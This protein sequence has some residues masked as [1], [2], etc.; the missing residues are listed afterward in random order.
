MIAP[1]MIEEQLEKLSDPS[2]NVRGSALV[3]LTGYGPAAASVPAL[4]RLAYRVK[5][6]A[7]GVRML[8]VDAVASVGMNHGLAVAALREATRDRSSHVQRRARAKL[9]ALARYA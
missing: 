7:E 1:E 8:A 3:Y 9:A 4:L 5:D 2:P 6:E